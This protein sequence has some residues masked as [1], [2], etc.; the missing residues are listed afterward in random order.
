MSV[1]IRASTPRDA[2]AIVDLL[3]GAGLAAQAESRALHWK[4]WQP[5]DDWSAPRSFVMERQGE[6][7]AHAAV[8]P[9]ACAWPGHRMSVLHMVDWAASPG[10]VGAG[11][12]LAKS[13][14]AYADALIAIDGSADTLRMLPAMGFRRCGTGTGYVRVLRP[15]RYLTAQAGWGWKTVPKFLSRA[16]WRLAAPDPA[17]E[18]GRAREIAPRELSVLEPVLPKLSGTTPIME[19]SLALLRYML[20][21]PLAAMRLH[22]VECGGALRGYFLL[23]I[24]PG[25]ARL[26][27]YWIDSEVIEDWKRLIQ[28][29]VASA[30][31]IPDVVEV[32]AIAS[33]PALASALEDLGFHRRY[34]KPVQILTRRGIEGPPACP[35]VQMLES[36]GAYLHGGRPKFLA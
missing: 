3:H 33:D 17:A 28:C 7:I 22:A 8:V 27:D 19:R 26:A 15:A 32:V 31:E 20:D 16:L 36:D 9:G 1:E 13:L 18:A 35:R 11:L 29:A 24:V 23:A 5:R 10:S 34:E 25:Q 30:R 21:C 12:A 6:V 2:A 4:Y 14:R